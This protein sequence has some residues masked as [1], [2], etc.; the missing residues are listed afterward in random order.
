MISLNTRGEKLT[1]VSDASV[2]PKNDA[3][4]GVWQLHATRDKKR[5]VSQPLERQAHSYRHALETFYLALQDADK[6]LKKP[7]NIT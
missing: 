3:A 2:Y 6:Q 5:H 1:L 7:H 4:S